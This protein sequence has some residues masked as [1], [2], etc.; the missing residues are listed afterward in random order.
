MNYK[1][2]EF[3]LFPTSQLC[4]LNPFQQVTM[5]WLIHHTNQQGTCFP[6]LSKLCEETGIGKTK[7]ID[8]LKEL[9]EMGL[10]SKKKRS[11]EAGRKSNLYTVHKRTPRRIQRPPDELSP[12]RETV[13][14]YKQENKTH[15]PDGAKES[16]DS[17]NSLLNKDKVPP[18]KM[19]GEMVYIKSI[20]RELNKEIRGR[21][22]LIATPQ[23][24]YEKVFQEVGL[25]NAKRV[26]DWLRSDKNLNG[27]Y[28]YQTAAYNS[29]ELRLKWNRILERLISPSSRATPVDLGTYRGSDAQ[30]SIRMDTKRRNLHQG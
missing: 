22:G 11:S 7:L 27:E 13:T 3:S 12:V 8:T 9:V 14:N 29:D 21:G 23:K 6:S 17:E 19:S 15:S 10:V 25:G 24:K 16:L 5:A 20:W 1:K 4:G 2:G 28:G 18:A 30:I 26:M